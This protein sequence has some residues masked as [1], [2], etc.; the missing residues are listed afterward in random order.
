M[1]AWAA[2]AC[3]GQDREEHNEAG[4]V[5]RTGEGLQRKARLGAPG[6]TT[7]AVPILGK[8]GRISIRMTR[9]A[10]LV[11]V[12]ILMEQVGGFDALCTFFCESSSWFVPRRPYLSVL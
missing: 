9:E 4:E 12:T 2:A 5:Q 6:W 11:T 8:F 3:L 7:I 1:V 10:W